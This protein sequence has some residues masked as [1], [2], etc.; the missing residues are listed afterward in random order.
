MLTFRHISDDLVSAP[1][2]VKWEMSAVV[3]Y[4]FIDGTGDGMAPTRPTQKWVPSLSIE[5]ISESRL[6]GEDEGENIVTI[7]PGLNLWHPASGWAMRIGVDLPVS[8]Q[9]ESDFTVL[10]QVG[11][12]INWKRMFK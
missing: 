1:L 5:I 11:N 10:L 12:H 4:S 2:R 3:S 7:L 9:Q 6:N 8:V